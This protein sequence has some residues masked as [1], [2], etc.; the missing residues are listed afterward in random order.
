M[1]VTKQTTYNLID[2]DGADIAILKLA[3]ELY[4]VQCQHDKNIIISDFASAEEMLSR[5]K[6]IAYR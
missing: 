2:L 5:I 6:S 3:I 4:I 1:D